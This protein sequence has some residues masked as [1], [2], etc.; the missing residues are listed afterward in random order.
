MCGR[1][2]VCGVPN[3]IVSVCTHVFAFVCV[4]VCVCMCEEAEAPSP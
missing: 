4:C 1:R 3:M 2:W